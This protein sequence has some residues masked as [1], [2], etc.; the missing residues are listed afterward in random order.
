MELIKNAQIDNI[1]I[2]LYSQKDESN[3]N[4]VRI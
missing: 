2:S 1:K 3:A 4:M